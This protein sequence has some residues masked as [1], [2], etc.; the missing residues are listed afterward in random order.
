MLHRRVKYCIIGLGGA[1]G[2]IIPTAIHHH[3]RPGLP[4]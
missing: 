4:Q 2:H 1:D 3:F